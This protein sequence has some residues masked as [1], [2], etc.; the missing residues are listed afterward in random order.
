MMTTLKAAVFYFA[1]IFGTGALLGTA[2][3]LWVA[4]QLG[5]RVA[6]LVEMPLMLAVMI[7][8]SRLVVRWVKLAPMPTAR[9]GMGLIALALILV[10]EFALVLRLRGLS[11]TEYFAALDPVIA[12][13]Y[14]TLLGVMAVLPIRASPAVRLGRR[15]LAA[16]AAVILAVPGGLMYEAYR[17]DVGLERLQRTAAEVNR[18][19]LVPGARPPGCPKRE[20]PSAA[21]S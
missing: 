5:T 9:I 7:V 8:A 6:E 19:P 18:C 12:V 16:T 13:P 10:A 2:R 14:Y 21:C 1:I 3:V 20:D 4:P 11:H 15:A 17:R